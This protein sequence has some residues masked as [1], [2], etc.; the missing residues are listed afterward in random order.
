LRSKRV[1]KDRDYSQINDHL[2]IERYQAPLVDDS[3]GKTPRDIF[4]MRAFTV[5]NPEKT[6]DWRLPVLCSMY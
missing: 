1:E 6:K 2:H 4:G 3:T 5:K